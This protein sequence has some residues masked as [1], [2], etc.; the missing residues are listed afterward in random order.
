MITTRHAKN[1]K[2]VNKLIFPMAMEGCPVPIRHASSRPLGSKNLP[3]RDLEVLETCISYGLK[4]LE[5]SSYLNITEK[6]VTN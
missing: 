1:K 2:N 4:L 6:D 5:K 3:V